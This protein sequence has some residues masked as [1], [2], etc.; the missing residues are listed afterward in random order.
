[1][2]VVRAPFRIPFGGGGSDLPAYYSK[3][4]GYLVTC[5]INKYMYISINIAASVRKIKI[6]YSNVEI[7][8]D[9]KDIKHDIVRETLR[10]LNFNQKIEIGSMADASAGTGLGSSSS[11]TVALLKG[12]NALLQRSVSKEQLAEDACEIE[13]NRIGKPIGKQDQYASALGG[14]F[15]MDIAKD[16]KVTVKNLN[17]N[18]ETVT[19]LQY[20]L[21]TF[22]TGIQRDANIILKEQSGVSEKDES[23]ELEAMHHIKRIGLGIEQSLI[24]GDIDN[25]GLL[26]NEHWET[27]KKISNKMSTNE[28][29]KWYKLALKNG[30]LGGKIMGAGG[31]GF[32]LF[33][34]K[35][36]KRKNLIYELENAGLHYMDYCIDFEGAKV[37]V[38][39]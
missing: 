33:C 1:M 25:L 39:I 14:L 23:K 13:I 2:I 12:M 29:D 16:G 4:G 37:L 32:F 11:Y 28:I 22:Y 31:G 36:G 20:R 9:I 10:F 17:L 38:D 8:D 15:A 18:K 7:V 5:A 3:Y 30:A 24:E 21:L 26:M 35:D 6:N 19:E 34:C 27:K